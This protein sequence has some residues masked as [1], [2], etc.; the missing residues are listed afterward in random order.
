MV[1]RILPTIAGVSVLCLVI[2][3]ALTSRAV[4]AQVSMNATGLPDKGLILIGPA[5]PGFEEKA[6]SVLNGRKD[7]TFET[8]KP[9]S[10]ILQNTSQKT[11]VAYSL[12][13]EYPAPKGQIGIWDRSFG[14]GSRLLDGGKRK[15]NGADD[16]RGPTI[17]PGEWKLITPKSY[18]GTESRVTSDAQAADQGYRTYLKSVADRL[19]GGELTVT[20]D[21]AFFEDGTFVGPDRAGYFDIF[22]ADV[23]ARHDLMTRV[24]AAGKTGQG[25]AQVASEIESAL[26]AQKTP[27]RPGATPADYYEYYKYQYATEFLNVRKQRGDQDALGIAYFHSFEHP[28]VFKK[29]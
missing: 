18:I 16:K 5:D 1:R 27:L 28:P 21:G 20:L 13:W 11:V 2:S 8:L 24:V 10:V 23:T 19:G 26:P 6:A 25:L 4:H 9:Y 7:F 12:R 15:T 22:K 3:V 29:D 17:G 14:Q